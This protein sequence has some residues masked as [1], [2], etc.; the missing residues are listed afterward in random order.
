MATADIAGL[1]ASAY[2]R[3]LRFAVIGGGIIEAD[4]ASFLA[5]TVAV[6][7]LSEEA[8][9]EFASGLRQRARF[10]AEP[11]PRAPHK[12]ANP[13]GHVTHDYLMRLA[14]AVARSP[15]AS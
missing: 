9:A 3:A 14:E 10:L 4:I 5:E 8:R 13:V 6:D 1:T 12:G 7:R 11:D 15:A 2:S